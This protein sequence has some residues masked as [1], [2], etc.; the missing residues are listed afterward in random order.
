[1]SIPM[2]DLQT[3]LNDQAGVS[4]VL[5]NWL[6]DSPDAV[7][8]VSSA[9]GEPPMMEG[10][11]EASHFLIRSRADT[12]AAA[13]AQAIVVHKAI[14]GTEGSFTAGSTYVLVAKTFAPPRFLGK[15]VDQ[16][17]IYGTTYSFTC[18]V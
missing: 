1:M 7:V 2:A 18:P 15:D 10:A 6:P 8:V 5:I 13:E 14:A 11:F 12:D 4:G 16:R 3:W 17:T 9:G